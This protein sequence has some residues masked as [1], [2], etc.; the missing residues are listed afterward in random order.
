MKNLEKLYNAINQD[1]S[2]KKYTLGWEDVLNLLKNKLK[3]IP[4]E[5]VQFSNEIL[6][7]CI[8]N[9]K[10]KLNK[11]LKMFAK[12][13]KINLESLNG[14]ESSKVV[15]EKDSFILQTAQDYDMSYDE[16]EHIKKL[17]PANFYEELEIF[18][19]IRAQQN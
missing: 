8:N 17:H 1:Y 11:E 15:V 7:D 12:E 9:T 16:V 13:L 4:N 6:L 18:I 19:K 10:G 3:D 5:N 2:I 14:L